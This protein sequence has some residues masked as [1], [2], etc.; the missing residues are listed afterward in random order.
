MVEKEEGVEKWACRS[1]CSPLSPS[2]LLHPGVD[3]VGV[4]P[5]PREMVRRGD[6]QV[7]V[8]APP[9]QHKTTE[10]DGCYNAVNMS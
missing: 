5:Q 8:V 2:L 1:G 10:C 3:G 7:L 9:F 4:L 6:V